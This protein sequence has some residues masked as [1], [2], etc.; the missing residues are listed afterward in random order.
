ME[1][2]TLNQVRK[3]LNVSHHKMQK[4]VKKFL[5]EGEDYIIQVTLHTNVILVNVQA[6]KT[7][8]QIV[9]A[10]RK[11]QE[12]SVHGKRKRKTMFASQCGW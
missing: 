2:R 9:E 11:K 7:I 10:W 12:N 8:K 1:T 5:H 4:L 6:I 3:Q